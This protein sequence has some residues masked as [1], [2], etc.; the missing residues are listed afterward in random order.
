MSKLQNTIRKGLFVILAALVLGV[1]ALSALFTG[2]ASPS[3]ADTV[4]TPV[5]AQNAA[6]GHVF[7]TFH[8]GTAIAADTNSSAFQLYPYPVIDY[9]WVIDQ[10]TT[11]TTTLTIQ[12]SN[13]NTNWS[14][15]PALVS[16][17]AS[18]ADG[19]VQAANMGRYTRVSADVTNTNDITITVKAVAK[20][21]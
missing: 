13:D 1:L 2:P 19:M 17:N 10:G 12:W 9:Q 8:D 18:D 7:V 11:N 20:K 15:G 6:G 16:N 14:D 4:P 5:A 3:Y 21:P